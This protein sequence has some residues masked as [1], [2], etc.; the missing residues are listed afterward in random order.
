MDRSRVFADARTADSALSAS[1]RT[2]TFARRQEFLMGERTPAW[3]GA[4]IADL[5]GLAAPE[6]GRFRSRVGEIN[7]HG[8]VYGG[9]LLGQALAAAARTV[10]ADRPATA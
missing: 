7:E 3:D 4:D 6:S 2:A 9:Q 5:L 8:R 10:P 1:T